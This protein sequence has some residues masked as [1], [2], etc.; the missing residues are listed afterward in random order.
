[1]LFETM[2]GNNTSSHNL[3][4]QMIASNYVHT[5]GDENHQPQIRMAQPLME[6][7]NSVFN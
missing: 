3:P 1:M 5:Q 4:R 2:G 6:R 7:K